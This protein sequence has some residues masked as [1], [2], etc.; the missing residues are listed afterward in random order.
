MIQILNTCI[1]TFL[2]II[3]NIKFDIRDNVS[4]GLFTLDFNGEFTLPLHM[5]ARE[6]EKSLTVWTVFFYS[7]LDLIV[8]IS[9]SLVDIKKIQHFLHRFCMWSLHCQILNFSSYERLVRTFTKIPFESYNS[10]VVGPL[11]TDLVKMEA[12]GKFKREICQFLAW[13]FNGE[14]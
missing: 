1:Y 4:H 14:Q 11:N 10:S 5:C 3:H 7:C 9:S 8:C 6:R 13:V 2:I 12:V